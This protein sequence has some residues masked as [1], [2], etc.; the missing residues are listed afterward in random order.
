MCEPKAETITVST[1]KSEPKVETISVTMPKSEPKTD[2][3]TVTTPISE[4][5]AKASDEIKDKKQIFQTSS[6]L[7]LEESSTGREVGPDDKPIRTSSDKPAVNESNGN[8]LAKD[9]NAVSK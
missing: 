4:T 9:V 2:T 8:S 7:A 3:I 6:G 1:P 5:K